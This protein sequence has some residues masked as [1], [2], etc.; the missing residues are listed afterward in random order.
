MYLN[1]LNNIQQ[2]K[3]RKVYGAPCEYEFKRQK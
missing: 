1:P 3:Y 2:A